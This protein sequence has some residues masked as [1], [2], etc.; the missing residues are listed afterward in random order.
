[1]NLLAV[2]TSS[3]EGSICLL[4]DGQRFSAKWSRNTG[5]KE[6]HSEVVTEKI[7]NLLDEASCS[8]NELQAICVSQGP[9]S[10]TGLRVG[11]NVAKVLG[12]AHDLPIYA[13]DSLTV[14]AHSQ[15]KTDKPLL[16]MTNAYKNMVFHAR[17]QFDEQWRAMDGPQVH[18]L[19]AMEN[20]LSE[21][22][23]VL[24]DGFFV[25]ESLFSDSFKSLLIREFDA[26]TYP[27][28]ESLIDLAVDPSYRD[29]T[30]DW[31]Q[32]VPL[33]LRPSAAEEKAVETGK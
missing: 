7:Q 10:F 8:T 29:S 9:G 13:F 28:A 33:Y 20:L 26:P 2:E 12:Y 31:N 23:Y 18:T 15:S 1:M 16:V 21:P 32:L 25:Y 3:L 19:N 27:Q 17:Y 24:G 4:K 5:K 11:I 6:S 30:I 22:H 14:L